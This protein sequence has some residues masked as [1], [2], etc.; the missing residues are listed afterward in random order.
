M[1]RQTTDQLEACAQAGGRVG[2]LR[3][4]RRKE[5]S[6]IWAQ[7]LSLH[8][9]YSKETQRELNNTHRMVIFPSSRSLDS[10]HGHG[11]TENCRTHVGGYVTFGQDL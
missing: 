1:K 2:R 4:V 9:E 11:A 5:Y 10:S 7:A 3:G 8:V 6:H